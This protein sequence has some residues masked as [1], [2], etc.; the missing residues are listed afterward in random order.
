MLHLSGG[1]AEQCGQILQFRDG[2]HAL[3]REHAAAL[4]LPVL[5][6]LQQHRSYQTGDRGV[7]GEDADHPGAALD[8]LID[9]LEQVGAPDLA[10]VGRREVA[11]RQHVLP[12]LVHQLS[13]LGETLSERGGQV[14]PAAED[15]GCVL[16]GEHAAQRGGDHALMG[17][18]NALQQVAGEMDTAALPHTAL[19]LPADRLGESRV[20]IAHHQLHASQ[21]A[22]LE[23]AEELA[24]EA[25]A[26]AVAHLEAQQL[27]ASVGIDAH[28]D[29]HG[30]RADL[31]GL[32]QPPMQVRRVEIDV[33]V[34]G[35]L[36]GPVQE[37]LHL[38]VDVLA[39]AAH[40]RLGDAALGA[41]GGHQSIDLSGRDP[42]D[43][44]LHD[45]GVE[46]LVHPATGLQDRGQEAP[47]AEFGDQQ[48][49][50]TH[51]GGQAA[52]PVAVAVAEPF[53]AALMAVGTQKGSDLQLDQLLQAVARQLG[54]QLPGFAAIQ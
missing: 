31:Q 27:P 29:D 30:P 6:L 44:G 23:R 14:I 13:G 2:G 41:Q 4:Q 37:G 3:G 38:L 33:G 54:D 26:F 45:H 12:G 34:A 24:P 22:F 18:W 25:L 48:V 1:D 19:Q 8:L 16:L 49:D 28:G 36:Q 32:A 17:L 46:G 21:A 15:L 20:G 10:P 9:P 52:G 50:V 42:A 51:L 40:L 39:D 11:E 35:L 53:L 5:V 43:V 7:V 47:L